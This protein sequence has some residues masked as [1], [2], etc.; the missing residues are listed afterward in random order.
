MRSQ[1]D[2]QLND[3]NHSLLE[4]AALI[5]D[6]IAKATDALKRQ[7]TE[8]AKQ[9][10]QN[11]DEIDAKEKDIE[12]LCLKVLLKQQPVASDLRLVSTALKMITDMER[13]GDH[14]ADISEITEYLAGQAYIKQLDHIP[15][16]ADATIRMVSDS[17]DAY[18]KKD[19]KLAYEVIAYDDVVDALFVQVKK[20]L[21]EL[22]RENTDNGEQAFDLL[23]IAKYF[24][25]IGD[26][27]VN[28]A[29]W[30]VFS[31]MGT[32]KETQIL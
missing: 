2:K 5:E 12:R 16:M 22:T 21:I 18:V 24:E 1:F 7:D 27:A 28:I 29:E 23:M 10:I 25:R 3:L 31:I 17:I 9:V 32:H 15:Q 4:M 6:A 20:D 26:H 14:A 8:L 13:I 30:V 19:V 11:D